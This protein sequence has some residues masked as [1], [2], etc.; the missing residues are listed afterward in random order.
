MYQAVR[1]VCV[2]GAPWMKPTCIIGNAE[3]IL[4]LQ[5]G[6]PGCRSHIPLQGRSPDGRAWTAV[7]SSYWPRFAQVMA[8]SWA[9]AAGLGRSLEGQ[10][11]AGWQPTAEKGVATSLEESGFT[12]SGGRSREVIGTRVAAGLQPVRRAS[13]CYFRMD[14]AQT[15]TSTCPPA[16]APVRLP[17]STHRP[18]CICS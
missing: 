9:W 17:A 13:L 11:L 10:H 12:P 1:C 2:D 16:P 4:S 15:S 6:C 5:A 14:W 8:R 18:S 7:A 3:S